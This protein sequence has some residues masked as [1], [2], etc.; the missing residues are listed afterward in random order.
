MYGES[1]SNDAECIHPLICVNNST[2]GC[3]GALKYISAQS[4]Y[5]RRMRCLEDNP[6]KLLID[7]SFDGALINI[8]KSLAEYNDT[9]LVHEQTVMLNIVG[10][11]SIPY[12]YIYP[13]V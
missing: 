5:G 11:S 4:L 8:R 2:C 10:K 9:I 12:I 7:G 3:E 1:C 13:I 6:R